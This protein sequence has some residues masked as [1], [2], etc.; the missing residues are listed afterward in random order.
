MRLL[1]FSFSSPSL[2]DSNKLD[3][4]KALL[5]R[6]LEFVAEIADSNFSIESV[7]EILE[8]VKRNRAS[9]NNNNK[10]TH[11]LRI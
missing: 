2:A 11:L 9:I 1:H 5:V 10:V 3:G 7:I 6:T 4:T 8:N